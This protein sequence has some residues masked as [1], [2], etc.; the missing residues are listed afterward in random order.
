MFLINDN[1]SIANQIYSLY[2]GPKNVER[3]ERQPGKHIIDLTCLDAIVQFNSYLSTNDD[4]ESS[5]NNFG[6]N[7]GLW[8]Y[9]S[10]F[11]HSCLP[12]TKRI[13]LSDVMFIY[14]SKKY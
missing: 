6:H 11:N 12:N 9:P 1:P 5:V 4:Y 13:F 7:E 3:R 2:S 8:L 14:S 10:Y